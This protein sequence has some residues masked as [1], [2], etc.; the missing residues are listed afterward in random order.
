MLTT[1]EVDGVLGYDL[2]KI[3]GS[4]NKPF[5]VKVEP[6]AF[7]ITDWRAL[8]ATYG[9]SYVKVQRGN[10][11]RIALVMRTW[12]PRE[13]AERQTCVA[14]IEPKRKSE[15]DVKKLL[16]EAEA[17]MDRLETME[18]AEL[19]IVWRRRNELHKESKFKMR[20]LIN[21]ECTRRYGCGM[22]PVEIRIPYNDKLDGAKIKATIVAQIRRQDIPEFIREWQV[23]N[24]KIVT[25]GR[26]NIGDILTNVHKPTSIG[27]TCV[28]EEVQKQWPGLPMTNGH[29]AFIGRD[30]AA[31]KVLSVCAMNIPRPTWFDM[32]CMWERVREQMPDAWKMDKKAWKQELFKAMKKGSGKM[33]ESTEIPNTKEV[34]QMRK[35]MKGLVVGP[36][37]KNNGELWG[38]CPVLYGK[39]LRN[40][41]STTGG[42]DV[43]YPAKMSAYRKR[44]YSV[45][46]LPAQIMREKPL[47]KNQRGGEKDM[48]ELFKRIYKRRGWDRY[49]KFNT[50]GGFNIPYVLLKAKN[51]TDKETRRAKIGKVRPIAPGT[52][53]PMRKL[54]HYVGRAWSFVTA[55]MQ[56]EHFVL[57]KTKEAVDFLKEAERKIAPQGKMRAVILDIEGCYPN[58]P[59]ETIRFAMRKIV[60]E[61]RAQGYEGVSVPK[62]SDTRTCAWCSKRTTNQMIPFEVMLDV[63]EFSLDFAIVKMPDGRLRRQ[64]EGIPMGDPLSP[65]MTIATCAW[66]EK[67]WMQQLDARDKQRFVAKRF[68]DDIL[69]IYAENDEW[70]YEKFEEDFRRSECYQEPLKLEEGTGGT[71]L[72]TRFT[73]ERNGFR[74]KLKNDNENGKAKIWRYQHF[75]S[76]SSFAQ[77]RATLTACL[78][79][80]NLM[81]SDRDSLRESALAKVGEF[82]KLGYPLGVL[83]KAC[84]L[85]GFVTGQG[86]WITVRDTI[87][88]EDGEPST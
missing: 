58:M 7:D 88:Q 53:H 64:R 79:K 80:V 20:Q 21:M 78:K 49:A 83:R 51:M 30:V 68:M 43:V 40:M 42:Y 1:Y 11:D 16:D 12:R 32:F 82:K 26:R 28:C 62:Y 14:Y 45:E 54:M 59:K 15:A 38:M 4:T 18:D 39:A 19:E 65:G 69:M 23:A 73:I 33:Q 34:F 31:N 37:D 47:P 17:A 3:V 48:I 24:V 41:Y 63:M 74:Y 75:H 8:R 67:E 87:R 5:T 9:D 60:Q 61:C 66:M 72:E 71:F 56:G 13:E 25:E 44:R 46:E 52:K 76:Y 2:G 29:I 27:R 36:V 86:V 10:G 6:G 77:K 55:R 85:M 81:A 70:D 22:R 35:K 57:S 84:A 50:K